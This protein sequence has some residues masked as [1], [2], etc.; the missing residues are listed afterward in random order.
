MMPEAY[1]RSI[2]KITIFNV[3]AMKKCQKHEKLILILMDKQNLHIN[4][5]VKK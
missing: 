5:V 2:A 4:V 3:A 1:H